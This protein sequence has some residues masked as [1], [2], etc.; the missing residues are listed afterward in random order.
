MHDVL[1][2]EACSFVMKYE[3]AKNRKTNGK[4]YEIESEIDKIQNSQEAKDIEKVE[5]LKDEL[6]KLE[7]EREV[8]NAKRYFAKNNLKGERPTKS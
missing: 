7:D 5:I 6:Q 3:A 1:L 8:E 2:M 4:K